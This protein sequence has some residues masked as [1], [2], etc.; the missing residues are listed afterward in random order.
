MV[1]AARRRVAG[2][3]IGSDPALKGIRLP[4]EDAFAALLVWKLCLNGHCGSPCSFTVPYC[5]VRGEG[6]GRAVWSSS[7]SRNAQAQKVLVRRAH[8]RID[9]ASLEN[10]VEDWDN[11]RSKGQSWLLP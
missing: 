6:E 2:I 4:D 1:A 7:C 3:P 5:G 9:Q 10:E 11:A 8:S